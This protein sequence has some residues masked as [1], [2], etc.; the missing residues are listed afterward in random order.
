MREPSS[1]FNYSNYNNNHIIFKREPSMYS[2]FLAFVN[3]THD[4]ITNHRLSHV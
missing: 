4:D 2:T 3:Q 1:S